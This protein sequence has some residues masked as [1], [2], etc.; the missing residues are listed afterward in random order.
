MKINKL[1]II[2]I[3]WLMFVAMF[4][5]C[6]P[7]FTLSVEATEKSGLPSGQSSGT[8]TSAPSESPSPDPSESPS[9]EPSE[10][11]TPTEKPKDNITLPGNTKSTTPSTPPNNN[12]VSSSNT[13]SFN[14]NYINQNLEFSQQVS[15]SSNLTL[16]NFETTKLE[17]EALEYLQSQIYGSKF[18]DKGQQ[19]QQI[20]KTNTVSTSSLTQ[21]QWQQ[22]FDAEYYA[23]RYPD[24]AEAFGNNSSLLLKHFMEFG[25]HEGRAGSAFFDVTVYKLANNDLEEAFGDDMILYAK[26]FFKY[27]NDENRLTGFTLTSTNKKGDSSVNFTIFEL[28]KVKT[29][30]NGLYLSATANSTAK[31]ISF[32]HKGSFGHD[33]RVSAKLDLT[34]LNTDNLKFYVYNPEANKLVE[35]KNPN[36]KIDSN[37]Y[38]HFSTPYGGDIII[39]D[40]ELISD[41]FE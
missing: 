20:K 27:G 15:G 40:N 16:N 38:L 1:L 12:S 8:P 10:S 9:P 13:T 32:D 29:V 19:N 7:V 24:V 18:K 17:Q 37:G 26:H 30:G 25:L 35:I 4:V 5:S 22:I 2:N 28:N 41:D 3:A 34:G 33:I 39:F 21:N 31:V 6:I 14:S 11:P 36:Y 23:N